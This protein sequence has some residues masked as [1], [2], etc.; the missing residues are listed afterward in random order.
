MFS[1]AWVDNT[2]KEGRFVYWELHR[3]FAERGPY[4]YTL[5]Y[6]RSTTGP[7]EVVDMPSVED[8]YFMFDPEDRLFGKTNDLYYRVKLET[9]ESTRYSDP[10]RADGGLPRR[11]W[12]YAREI[13]RKEYLFYV[14]S[15]F[16]VRGCLHKRRNWGERCTTCTDEVTAE[17][18][19]SHCSVCYGTGIIGGYHDP[20]EFWLMPSA[21][22]Q[23]IKTDQYRGMVGDIDLQ[24]RCVAYPMVT[25]GDVWVSADADYRYVIGRGER[26]VQV[27]TQFRQKPLILHIQM[28]LSQYTDVKYDISSTDC[29]VN[30]SADYNAEQ[31][32]DAEETTSTCEVTAPPP[33]Y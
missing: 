9:A 26:A 16:G 12:L 19:Q 4:V 1:R 2:F 3:A 33:D 5:E 27:A 18:S 20:V 13:I 8:T 21:P 17:V 31:D 25:G 6:A 24:A 7:W 10:A 11:D 30:G 15:P 22:A 14:K 29:A 28:G 23:K 32:C